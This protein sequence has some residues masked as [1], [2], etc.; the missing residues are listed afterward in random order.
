[1]MA[2]WPLLGRDAHE[3]DG[4][5]SECLFSLSGAIFDAVDGRVEEVRN[6]IA[7]VI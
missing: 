4:G 7:S 5:G 2:S 1:M 3:G 6:A